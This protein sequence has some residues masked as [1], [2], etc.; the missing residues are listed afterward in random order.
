MDSE[1]EWQDEEV[2]I[3]IGEPSTSSTPIVT[4]KSA[5]RRLVYEDEQTENLVPSTSNAPAPAPA[6]RKYNK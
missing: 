3:T 5:K 2:S 1:E 6:M 4:T